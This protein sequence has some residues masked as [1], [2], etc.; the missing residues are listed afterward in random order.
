MYSLPHCMKQKAEARK[1]I[2]IIIIYLLLFNAILGKKNE[3]T[4]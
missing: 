2:T 1:S 4:Q 3:V